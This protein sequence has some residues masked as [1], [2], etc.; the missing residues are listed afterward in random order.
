MLAPAAMRIRIGIREQLAVFGLLLVLVG[1]AVISLP[2]WQFV[3]SFVTEV[4]TEGLSET[5]SLKAA[6]LASHLVL[7]QSTT[8]SISTR[9]IVQQALNGYHN[10]NISQTQ[11]NT[12]VCASPPFKLLLVFCSP[13]SKKSAT[14]SL[15]QSLR[16]PPLTGSIVRHLPD[17]AAHER[18]HRFVAGPG[19]CPEFD[20]P[21]H[22]PLQ[23]HQGGHAR[24][25]LAL[26][27]SR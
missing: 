5:A 8:T 15:L 20:R 1:L 24:D 11:L 17:R 16:V 19:L 2:T 22:L 9:L 27:R 13:L 26:Q 21:S 25:P 12:A 7:L 23:H 3:H 4:K 18:L 10:N 6:E 14:G